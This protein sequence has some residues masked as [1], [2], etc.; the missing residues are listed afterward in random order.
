MVISS[1]TTGVEK[2][3]AITASGAKKYLILISYF[4]EES[5]GLETARNPMAV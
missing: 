1:A 2:R 4:V 3:T 5:V